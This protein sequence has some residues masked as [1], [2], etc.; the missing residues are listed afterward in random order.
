MRLEPHCFFDIIFDLADSL[1]SSFNT[2][3]S[4]K[5]SHPSANYQRGQISSPHIRL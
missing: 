3:T 5:I 4:S 1:G 2:A